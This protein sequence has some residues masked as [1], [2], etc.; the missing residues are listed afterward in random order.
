M[1]KSAP[2]QGAPPPKKN[3]QAY[4]HYQDPK[5]TD[6]IGCRIFLEERRHQDIP[7]RSSGSSCRPHFVKQGW[8]PWWIVPYRT[9]KSISLRTDKGVYQSCWIRGSPV[10]KDH[11]LCFTKMALEV[12]LLDRIE[13]SWSYFSSRKILYPFIPVVWD[14]GWWKYACAF[15][16]GHPV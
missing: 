3:A 16:L 7:I 12:K 14:W 1:Q 13:V 2:I 4:F 15:F 10:I 6:S 5:S 8:G 11:W 9:I